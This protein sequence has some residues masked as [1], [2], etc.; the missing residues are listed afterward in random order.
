MVL[1][2]VAAAVGLIAGFR[3][4]FVD[5]RWWGFVAVALAVMSYFGARELRKEA[6]SATPPESSQP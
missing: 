2:A 5:L 6:G 1:F 3:T 4:V